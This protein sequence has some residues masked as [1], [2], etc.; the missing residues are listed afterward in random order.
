MSITQAIL[1]CLYA[2]LL[3]Q[4]WGVALYLW[5]NR[6]GGRLTR[7]L[8][9]GSFVEGMLWAA[10]IINIIQHLGLPR[11]HPGL[12]FEEWFTI[13]MLL[14]KLVNFQVFA[15]YIAKPGGQHERSKT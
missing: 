9:A 2:F 4:C 13:S 6:N 10:F 14:L 15:F 8:V 5:R 1:C 11:P 7:I 12:R 3:A